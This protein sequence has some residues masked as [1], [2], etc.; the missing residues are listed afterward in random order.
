MTDRVTGKIR[1]LESY[2]LYDIN[3]P[4]QKTDIAFFLIYYEFWMLGFNTIQ[5]SDTGEFLQ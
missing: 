1:N 4:M 2:N 3:E 5:V